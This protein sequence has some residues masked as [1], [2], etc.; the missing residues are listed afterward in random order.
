MFGH[1]PPNEFETPLQHL[2]TCHRRDMD[3]PWLD[4]TATASWRHFKLFPSHG[5]LYSLRKVYDY[6]LPSY[7]KRLSYLFKKGGGK[8]TH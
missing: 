3:I 1:V 4:L 5:Q 8:K 2:A 6:L 7:I